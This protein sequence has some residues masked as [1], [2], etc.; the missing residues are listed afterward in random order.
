MNAKE[1][2]FVSSAVF[3]VIGIAVLATLGAIAK[4]PASEY[5]PVVLGGAGVGLFWIVLITGLHFRAEYEHKHG[6]ED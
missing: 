4:V 2:L 3:V 6:I 1:I 5:W